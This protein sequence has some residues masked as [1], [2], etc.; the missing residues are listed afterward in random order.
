MGI[1]SRPCVLLYLEG[2]GKGEKQRMLRVK[3]KLAFYPSECPTLPV[4][5]PYR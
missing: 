5:C 3:E 2:G 4:L 1:I